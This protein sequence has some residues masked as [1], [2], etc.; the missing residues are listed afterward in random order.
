MP[1]V[2]MPCQEELHGSGEGGQVLLRDA[3]GD[4]SAFAGQAQCVYLDPPFMTGEDF[5][6]RMR[7]GERGWATGRDTLTL[8]AYSDRFATKRPHVAWRYRLFFSASG[9]PHGRLCPHHVRPDL[10]RAAFRK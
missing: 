9:Q 1:W 6:L 3:R 2:Q 4:Y 8:P 5:F 10:W 7:V